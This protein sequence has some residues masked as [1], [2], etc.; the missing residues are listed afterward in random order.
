MRVKFLCMER[1]RPGLVENTVPF[2]KRQFWKFNPEFLVEWNAPKILIQ[3][4]VNSRKRPPR[5]DIL[6]VF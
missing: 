4:G 1:D 3:H 5:L 2:D 6:D